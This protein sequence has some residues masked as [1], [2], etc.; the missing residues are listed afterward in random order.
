MNTKLIQ[1]TK[2]KHLPHFPEL[3]GKD[4][5]RVVTKHFVNLSLWCSADELRMIT[6][7]I[8]QSKVDNTIKYNTLLLQRYSA[9]IQA[10][11]KEYKGFKLN[12]N[13]KYLRVT[14]KRLIELGLLLINKE[15]NIY[16]INPMLTYRAEYMKPLDYQYICFLYQTLDDLKAG[17]ILRF[18]EEYSRIV[19]EYLSKK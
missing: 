17:F 5:T 10:A 16:T 8:Y 19:N 2:L 3:N 4:R 6:W 14:F 1:Q 7:L 11:N 18:T 15:A 13:I 12:H 9:A